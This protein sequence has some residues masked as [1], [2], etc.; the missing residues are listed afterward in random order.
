MV[1]SSLLFSSASKPSGL[2]QHRNQIPLIGAFAGNWC[3]CYTYF[4]SNELAETF[5]EEELQEIQK[6]DIK[7]LMVLTKI[8]QEKADSIANCISES[9]NVT[10]KDYNNFA[11][12]LDERYKK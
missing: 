10:I 12:K 2:Y 8:F 5:T 9:N 11:Q 7:K 3:E 6:D 4:V 1:A